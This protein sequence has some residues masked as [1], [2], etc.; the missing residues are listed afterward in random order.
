MDRISDEVGFDTGLKI[1]KDGLALRLPVTYLAPRPLKQSV[2]Q[3]TFDKRILEPCRGFHFNNPS[4][5]WRDGAPGGGK[6]RL[7]RGEPLLFPPQWKWP[8]L[9]RLPASSS[10]HYALMLAATS[11][12]LFQE[13]RGGF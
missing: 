7:P 6:S 3:G 9:R 10:L 4:A 5:A 1:L 8:W 12:A 13:D 2:H 11:T